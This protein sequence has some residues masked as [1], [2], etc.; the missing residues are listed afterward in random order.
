VLDE[1]KGFVDDDDAGITAGLARPGE[2][3]SDR[4][5]AALELDR[6]ATHAAG[7]GHCTRDI[8][9]RFLLALTS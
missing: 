2:I 3:A 6:F 1:P 7:I 8:R 4:V 5:A 9:H